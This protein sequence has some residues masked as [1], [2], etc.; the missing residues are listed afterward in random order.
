MVF[1]QSTRE[2]RVTARIAQVDDLAEENGGQKVRVIR[3]ALSAV[4][5]KPE[6]AVQRENSDAWGPLSQQIGSHRFPITPEMPGNPGD[7][8][9]LAMEPEYLHVFLPADQENPTAVDSSTSQA[10]TYADGKP[11]I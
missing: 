11:E 4:R 5:K 10:R 1:A 3:Q 6:K 8:P 9:S 7:G 2:G